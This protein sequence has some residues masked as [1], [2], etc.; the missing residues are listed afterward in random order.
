MHLWNV[1]GPDADGNVPSTVDPPIVCAYAAVGDDRDLTSITW[2][3]DGTLVAV[4]CYDCI[5]RIYDAQGKGYFVQQQQEV[6]PFR[7]VTRLLTDYQ[8]RRVRYLLFDFLHLDGGFCLQVLTGQLAYG[9]SRRSDYTRSIV[10]IKVSECGSSQLRYTHR[11]QS[12][13]WTSTGC[14][15]HSSSRVG[16]TVLSTSCT[17]TR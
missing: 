12:A 8:L 4:G 11:N 17:W 2:S 6:G 5:L 1:P 10:I 3:P 14:R 16:L 7:S 13:A 15:I 9:T